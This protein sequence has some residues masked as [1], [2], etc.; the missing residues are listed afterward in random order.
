ME[1]PV[2][3]HRFVLHF[4]VSVQQCFTLL[5][6][7]RK[8]KDIR[9]VG[10]HS[11]DRDHRPQVHIA[12]VCRNDGR[13]HD[14]FALEYDSDKY[15]YI[16]E[17]DVH[18]PSILGMITTDINRLNKETKKMISYTD[19]FR[20]VR[21]FLVFS[22]CFRIS[23]IISIWTFCISKSSICWFIIKWSTFSCKVRIS[24]SDFRLII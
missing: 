7:E 5:P 19:P 4:F 23:L 14:H 15:P 2:D 22:N 18:N 3:D 6:A 10:A 21:Y 24:S 8:I 1:N 16:N 17:N 13:Q 20:F 9:K 11:A 12:V